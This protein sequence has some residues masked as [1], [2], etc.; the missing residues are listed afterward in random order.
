MS[1]SASPAG[2][3]G[4]NPVTTEL[5]TRFVRQRPFIPFEMITVDGRRVEV[6]HSDFADLERFAAAVT[7]ID[8]AGHVEIIDA[9][10]IVSIRTLEPMP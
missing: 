8:D 4:G 6:P 5:M 9:S 10:L 7:V 1:C 3:E 2:P